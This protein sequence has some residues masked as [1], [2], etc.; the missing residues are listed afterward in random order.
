MVNGWAKADA[1]TLRCFEARLALLDT[2][3][4]RATLVMRQEGG[5]ALNV[6][7]PDG[8]NTS[9]LPFLQKHG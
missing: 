4:P 9:L 1:P 6:T 5:H 2:P 8:F 3:G 7:D